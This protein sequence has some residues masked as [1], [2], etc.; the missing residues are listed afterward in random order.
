MPLSLAPAEE[1]VA[2]ALWMGQLKAGQI[3]EAV[4]EQ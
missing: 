3:D 2:R 1:T 4:L